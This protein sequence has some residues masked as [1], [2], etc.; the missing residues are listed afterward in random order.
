MPRGV[1]LAAPASGQGK[2]LTALS[3]LRAFQR[4]G[5]A[6]VGAKAG[7]DYI[8]PGYHAAASGRPSFNLDPWAMRPET[9][10]AIVESIDADYIL[11]E[12]VMGLFDGAGAKG[13][14]GSTADLA[15]ITGWPVVMVVDAQGQSGSVAALLKGFANHRPDITLS[16]IIL[17]RV[18]SDRHAGMLRS[19]IETHLPDLA[20]L[21][22][23][24]RDNRLALPS[25]HLGLVLAGEQPD[26]DSV[27]DCSSRCRRGFSQSG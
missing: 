24:P 3:L 17:N 19:A 4:T 10:S 11:C 18:G 2:T 26:L 12:G 14:R 16:G 9:I 5:R 1:I 22:T 13:D 27:P 21:G 8:D 7:P 25:R 6:V 23:I 20:V 15:A